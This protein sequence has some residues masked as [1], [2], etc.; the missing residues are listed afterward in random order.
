MDL[1]PL[2]AEDKN[3]I[4]TTM[5]DLQYMDAGE[6]VES[7]RTLIRAPLF[8]LLTFLELQKAEI[9]KVFVSTENLYGTVRGLKGG[10]VNELY[11]VLQQA[12]DKSNP[13]VD[14]ASFFYRREYL[15]SKSTFIYHDFSR[16]LCPETIR[17]RHSR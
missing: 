9:G 3:T 14:W 15:D 1:P 8:H 5:G 16:I 12:G 2:S 7:K 10:V 17:Y 13:E 4:N 6:D 11:D